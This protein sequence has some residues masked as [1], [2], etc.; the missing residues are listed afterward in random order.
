MGIFK[1]DVAR[2]R[3]QHLELFYLQ[4]YIGYEFGFKCRGTTKTLAI[5]IR[6]KNL[7]FSF[8]KM[9]SMILWKEWFKDVCGRSVVFY[10]RLRQMPQ[11]QRVFKAT[12]LD[13]RMHVT[14]HAMVIMQ[15]TPPT[16]KL[17]LNLCEL[18]DIECHGENFSFKAHSYGWLQPQY[19]TF[20]GDRI[21]ELHRTLLYLLKKEQFLHYSRNFGSS[22]TSVSPTPA[23]MRKRPH[24]TL[25]ASPLLFYRS[26][27][28]RQLENL[29]RNYENLKPL[30]SPDK[31]PSVPHLYSNTPLFETPTLPPDYV[32]SDTVLN[33]KPE[34]LSRFASKSNVGTRRHSFQETLLLKLTRRR[35]AEKPRNRLAEMLQKPASTV[36]PP[37]SVT[38]KSRNGSLAEHLMHRSNRSLGVSAQSTPARAVSMVQMR[39]AS[40]QSVFASPTAV[41]PNAQSQANSRKPSQA[42]FIVEEDEDH[43]DDEIDVSA[44]S[45]EDA[46]PYSMPV[47]T[48]APPFVNMHSM[49][50]KPT[51]LVKPVIDANFPLRSVGGQLAKCLNKEISGEFSRYDAG[52]DQSSL[53]STTTPSSDFATTVRSTATPNTERLDVASPTQASAFDASLNSSL[54]IDCA[55]QRGRE[56]MKWSDRRNSQLSTTTSRGAS[57]TSSGKYT[58]AASSAQ[59][60]AGSVDSG[61]IRTSM[62]SIPE[63]ISAAHSESTLAQNAAASVRS[64]ASSATTAFNQETPCASSHMSLEV[65]D[66]EL[67]FLNS[68][69][70]LPAG[71]Q[72]PA[73]PGSVGSL[74]SVCSE[75]NPRIVFQRGARARTSGKSQTKQVVPVPPSSTPPPPPPLPPRRAVSQ[76]HGMAPTNS[77][78]ALHH[79]N[80]PSTSNAH[81]QGMADDYEEIDA[82]RPKRRIPASQPTTP[83]GRSMHQV[84]LLQQQPATTSQANLVDYVSICPSSTMTLKKLQRKRRGSIDDK[85]VTTPITK[86]NS[87][88]YLDHHR[89]RSSGSGANPQETTKTFAS[90]ASH[91]SHLLSRAK[92]STV[93]TPNNGHFSGKQ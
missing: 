18:T 56:R 79:A 37:P 35:K 19:F 70:S 89:R 73:S 23:F 3:S 45:D 71:A 43:Y 67:P 54:R 74:I 44:E 50:Q 68:T 93:S 83:G 57:D 9:D 63:V 58:M 27:R 5:I 7:V 64:Y 88:H 25:P 33:D 55:I 20:T 72:T 2:E 84:R 90:S 8:A 36:L 16:Q 62:E 76:V 13:A 4:N 86:S 60:T 24:V 26:Q 78:S 82:Y 39:N 30:N 47:D 80:R 59:A 28:F 85:Q 81:W 14:K 34:I 75:M 92:L 77:N 22:P 6:G 29:P 65:P 46:N 61:S 52:K 10:M 41:T 87:M 38:P 91:L 69:V 1:N 40:M 11:D 32:N 51:G 17:F 49:N 12:S 21:G 15:E 48:M 42:H 31:K 66:A 53:Q